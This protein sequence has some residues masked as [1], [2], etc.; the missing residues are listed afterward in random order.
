[1]VAGLLQE[2]QELHR[3]MQAGTTFRRACLRARIALPHAPSMQQQDV[4]RTLGV[5]SVCGSK[6]PLADPDLAGSRKLGWKY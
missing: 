4:A 6:W 1:M 3:R 5:S 2:S